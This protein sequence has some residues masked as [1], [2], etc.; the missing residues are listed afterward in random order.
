MFGSQQKPNVI[1][2]SDFGKCKRSSLTISP[3]Q[4]L[5]PTTITTHLQLPAIPTDFVAF[6]NETPSFSL[7]CHEYLV[8]KILDSK[9]FCGQLKFKVKWEGYGPDHNS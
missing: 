7:Q 5:K 2:G 9:M 4:V 6:P 8:E 1:G 3:A